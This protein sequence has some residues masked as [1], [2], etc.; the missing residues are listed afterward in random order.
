MNQQELR[1]LVDRAAAEGWTELNLSSQRLTEL[2]P[3]IGQLTS[4]TVLDLWKNQLTVVPP[5]IGQ[6]TSLTKLD[7]S[8]NKLTAVPPD[9]GQLTSLTVLDLWKNQLTAVPSEIGRLT[10]LTSLDLSGNQLAAVPPEILQLTSLT[11]LDLSNNQLTAVP[12]EIGQ[13]TSLTKLNL[14]SNQLTVVPPEI[15]Q[16][17][18]LTVLH[19]SGNELTAVP[20]EIGQLTSLTELN[21]RSNQLTAVPPEIGQLTSLTE[22][23]LRSNELTAVPP[24]IG[25]LTSLTWLY[26]DGNPIQTPPPEILNLDRRGQADLVQIRRYFQQLAEAGEDRLFEAKLLIVG[27]AGAGK[28]SLARKIQD[29]AAPLPMPEESTEGIDIHAWTFP[30]SGSGEEIVNRQSKIENSQFRVNIWDFGG[31][32]IYHATHQFFL[33]HRSLYVL[34]A[35]AREQK[36][37]FDYWLHA[38]KTLSGS[39][40]LLIVVNEKEGRQWHID[41]GRLHKQFGNLAATLNVNLK[42]NMGL[43]HLVAAIQQHITQL[44]HVGDALPRTWVNVRRALETELRP[45]ISLQT[46]LDICQTNGFTR[47]EDKLQLSG[48]LHDLGVC[49]H[50]QDDDILKR[51]VILDTEWGTDAVYRVLDNEQVVN[52]QGRFSRAD[53]ETIWHEDEYALMRGD[54]LAL[55]MKFQL[56][57]EIPH[58]AGHYIAPQ[59]LSQKPPAYDWPETGSLIL[60]YRAPDFMPKGMMAR[61]IVAM[62]RHIEDQWVWRNGVVLAQGCAR[63]EVVEFYGKREIRIRIAGANKRDLHNAVTW[64]LDKIFN[65]F[66]D[67]NYQQLIPCNCAACKGSQSPYFYKMESLKRRLSKGRHT[68]ECDHSFKMVNVRSLIDDAAGGGV[69][70]DDD[71]PAIVKRLIDQFNEAELKMCCSELGVE[72][73]DLGGNGRADNAREL[74]AYLLRQNRLPELTA[75]IERERP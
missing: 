1:Q 4:L 51:T 8:S 69:S 43:P 11:E 58:Q 72:Y 18:S 73:E 20:P 64:E 39:S 75:Y 47:L 55:M 12:P 42:T 44:P 62:H 2:P 29:S 70:G 59:L 56:C 50:F 45:H 34:V 25:Q 67:L 23:H 30:L 14:W 71:P 66:H 28:T 7:L 63:A 49:L 68:V 46:Y 37:D 61:F 27:E 6:L 52:N 26:L 57:Y 31:Q 53:L 15:G 24:E 16:L 40:P 10:N 19:L 48:Y 36:T 65:S 41:S 32:E 33:T 60:R 38:V 13:L 22:L 17:T 21:L 5:E 9:I 3:E 54:L 35:D 74:V